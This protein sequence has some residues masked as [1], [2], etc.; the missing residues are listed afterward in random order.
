[1]CLRSGPLVPGARQHGAQPRGDVTSRAATPALSQPD[2]FVYADLEPHKGALNFQLNL[3]GAA[4]SYRNFRCTSAPKYK[5][6][7]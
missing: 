5:L 1:M 3:K 6:H 4:G 2:E 7:W